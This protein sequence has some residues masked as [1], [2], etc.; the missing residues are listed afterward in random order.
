MQSPCCR[1]NQRGCVSTHVSVSLHV[2]RLG[3]GRASILRS[4]LRG[5]PGVG[6]GS[7]PSHSV[8][9]PCGRAGCG[10]DPFTSPNVIIPLGWG[11]GRGSRAGPC[12][13]L[14]RQVSG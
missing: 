4:L 2:Q 3:V 12:P 9:G 8:P 7:F 1:E 5:Q 11:W 13:Q 10:L 14:D 6:V